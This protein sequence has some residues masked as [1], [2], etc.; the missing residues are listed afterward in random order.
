[1]VLN[2]YHCEMHAKQSSP[3]VGFLGTYLPLRQSDI[4]EMVACIYQGTERMMIYINNYDETFF[5]G[6]SSCNT[7]AI[8]PPNPDSRRGN[9][10]CVSMHPQI[11]A[12]RYFARV[13]SGA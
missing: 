8:K 4:R 5:A 3:H 6:R 13:I 2:K 11:L 7:Q 10:G 12:R 9:V 1:M